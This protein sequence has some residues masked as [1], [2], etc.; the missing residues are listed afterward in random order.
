METIQFGTQIWTGDDALAGL[1]KIDSQRIFL[2]TDPF[3]VK[4]GALDQITM[5]LN[6]KNELSIF[7]DIQ[8]DPP[9]TKV[10][11]GIKALQS[12]KATLLVAVGGG[13]AIDAAKAMK[14][15]A[16]KVAE[17]SP[18]L[19]LI[20]IPTTSGTGSEVTNFAV[21]TNAE[22]GVKYPLVTDDILPKV[23]VLDANLVLS[24]PQNITV[25]TGMDVL[26]HCLEAY[27][28]INANDFSDALA[29]KGFQM[30]FE[31]LPR[32]SEDGNDVEARQKMHDA[33]CIAGMAFNMVNLGLNHGIA[34]A[35][36]ARYHIPHG[37]LNTILMPN[38]IAYNAEM[39]DGFWEEPNRA[40]TKYAN[41]ARLI[42]INAANPKLAVQS[43]IDNIIC[44]RKV[45]KMPASFSEYGISKDLFESTKAEISAAALKD[46]T[47]VA[48]PR[49]PTV[50]DVTD[51]L[52]RSF[53]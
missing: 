18:Q 42:N 25:D 10:V 26:T 11:E 39:N 46:G 43:L 20:A 53:M 48:N 22:K 19:D 23:A 1:E 52:N 47:T 31:Y 4:S 16:Q 37:R 28:S 3:M 8:P 21:I 33:S 44:L 2:V 38:I 51:I 32:V 29:E 9:I 34:H 35:A 49:K 41:L 15:F 36:G 30:V 12:F 5:H 6:V 27:V 17:D 45:L 14:Y 40:A 13:S 24:A 50:A 7:S